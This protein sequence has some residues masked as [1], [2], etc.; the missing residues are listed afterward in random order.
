[1]IGKNNTQKIMEFFLKF[2]ERKFHLREL[3][4]LTKLSL[5]TIKDITQK[6]EKEL[7]LKSKKE[8]VVKNFYATRNSKFIQ[9]KRVY[10]IYSIFSSGLLDYLKDIYEEPE[11][12]VLFG[13]YSKG[14]DISQS[15]IDIVIISNSSKDLDLSK[16][17]KKL[18]RK[19]KIY[20][21]KIKKIEKDFL[22]TLVNGIVLHGYLT[23]K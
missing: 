7:L 6:L 11:A 15:D 12:I 23:I 21:I 22:N 5:P 19:I 14:E 16:F 20:E 8:K 13:S 4:R 9:F 18:S 1:M 17:E 3:E 2:P 10:N